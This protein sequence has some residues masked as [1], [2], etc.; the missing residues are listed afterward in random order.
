MKYCCVSLLLLNYNSH[1]LGS[2]FLAQLLLLLLFTA[3]LRAKQGQ[4]RLLLFPHHC[5]RCAVVGGGAWSIMHCVLVPPFHYRHTIAVRVIL[6]FVTPF[7]C[8]FCFMCNC[9]LKPPIALSCS[10]PSCQHFP[11][12]RTIS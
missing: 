4:C 1:V 9:T 5:D 11:R 10:I 3:F 7:G 6:F 8:W 12:R 2:L